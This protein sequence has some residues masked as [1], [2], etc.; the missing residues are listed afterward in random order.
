MQRITTTI[1]FTILLFSGLLI[2]CKKDVIEQPI[3]MHYDYFPIEANAWTIYDVDSTVWNNFNKKIEHYTYQIK[4]KIDTSFIDDGG[5]KSWRLERYKRITSTSNWQLID[6]WHVRLTPTTAEKVEENNRI[7][8]LAF[9]ITTSTKWN[10]NTYNMLDA[11]SYKYQ[12]IH[13]PFTTSNLIADSS[14]TVIQKPNTSN[15][16][17][18]SNAYEIY[19]KNI[20]M[21]KKEYL[22]LYKNL[23]DTLSFTHYF[24]YYNSHGK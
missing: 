19:A 10:A 21:V 11:E 6:I 23:A 24:Y 12:D 22:Y 3:N 16:V 14:V 20:G 17:N 5:T 8:K 9:P 7:I 4:E 15:L 2:S 13:Q 1:L 18:S